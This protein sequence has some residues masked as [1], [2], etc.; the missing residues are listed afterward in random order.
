[1]HEAEQ[2]L[3]LAK[4]EKLRQASEQEQQRSTEH[5]ALKQER[6]RRR[7]LERRL[8]EEMAKHNEIMEQTIKLREKQK[9]QAR[10]LTR[11]LPVRDAHL[12][13]EQFAASAGHNV[14]ACTHVIVTATAC[15][16]FLSKLGGRL[17]TWKRRW[18][19]FDRA[20]RALSYYA[21]RT[22]AKPPRGLVY[23]QAIEDVFVD[24]MG[25]AKSPTPQL[26]F[27][28]KTSDRA[29]YLVAPSADAMRI[30]VD[31]IFTGAEGYREFA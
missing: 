18:F 8:A 26:T 12:N 20:A 3:M 21:D 2:L 13:L 11:Y 4:A 7:E 5:E 24:H 15:R 17:R 1:L 16:G 28:V 31:V 29:I 9:N 22:E 25:R 14:D 30:W 10:P 6:K 23:F 27:C 19:V